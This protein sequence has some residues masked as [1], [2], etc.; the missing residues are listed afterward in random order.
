MKTAYVVN[1]PKIFSILFA[2]I[3]PILSARTLSKIQIFSSNSSKWKVALLNNIPA[4]QIPV[5]YGGTKSMSE[6]MQN[7]FG[8][9]VNSSEN[10]FDELVEVTVGAGEKLE[11]QYDVKHPNTSLNWRFKTDNFDIC[12][13]LRT[14]DKNLIPSDRVDSHVNEVSGTYMCDKPGTYVLVFDNTYSVV[15]PKT[16]RYLVTISSPDD[17]DEEENTQM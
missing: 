13:G 1:A 9:K 2:L 16:L 12:F 3:K 17:S 4:D 15:R 8:N 7:I 11:A 10:E 6:N 14:G 5:K